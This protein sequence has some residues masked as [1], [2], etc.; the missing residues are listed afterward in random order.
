MTIFI[1][2]ILIILTCNVG[3]GGNDMFSVF[4][5]ASCAAITTLSMLDSSFLRADSTIILWP[6]ELKFIYFYPACIIIL[7]YLL[8]LAVIINDYI[9]A[10]LVMFC[11][12]AEFYKLFIPIMIIVGLL[13]LFVGFGEFTM[14]VLLYFI[15]MLAL[16]LAGMIVMSHSN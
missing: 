13:L 11:L 6:F 2:P 1:I 4:L 8:F 14:S 7:A 15:F 12:V 9:V 16:S 3:F 5:I 10:A